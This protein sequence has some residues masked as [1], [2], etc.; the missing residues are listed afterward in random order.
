M[1]PGNGGSYSDPKSGLHS[2]SRTFST[3]PHPRINSFSSS[4]R[5]INDMPWM[6][7]SED[8]DMLTQ[9]GGLDVNFLTEDHHH[10]P[11][12]PSHL[13]APQ[14]DSFDGSHTA[15]PHNGMNYLAD[16]AFEALN[17][18]SNMVRAASQAH[19]ELLET[20]GPD[21]LANGLLGAR[22]Q[23]LEWLQRYSS[24][25]PT[26]GTDPLSSQYSPRPPTYKLSN[27]H[28]GANSTATPSSA[29]PNRGV[30][31]TQISPSVAAHAGRVEREWSQSTADDFRDNSSSS[32][33][34]SSGLDAAMAES[35]HSP[36]DR[37]SGTSG[38]VPSHRLSLPHGSP[39]VSRYA[40]EDSISDPAGSFDATA[41]MPPTKRSRYLPSSGN[42]GYRSTHS[43]R[44][45][46]S[47]NESSSDHAISESNRA[48]Q[49]ASEARR[50]SPAATSASSSPR[51]LTTPLAHIQPFS[52]SSR[53][54]SNSSIIPPGSNDPYL[55]RQLHAPSALQGGLAVAP[56]FS[57]SNS[58]FSA[59][60]NHHIPAWVQD[61]PEIHTLG[62]TSAL[63]SNLYPPMPGF[64]A[65][66]SA[67][68]HPAGLVVPANLP[69]QI[70]ASVTPA[71]QFGAIPQPY[72]ATMA[73]IEPSLTIDQ[74]IS[75]SRQHA[76][77]T[78]I[79]TPTSS[80]RSGKTPN[81]STANYDAP[82]ITKTVSKTGR[83]L[84]PVSMFRVNPSKS[85]PLPQVDPNAPRPKG[86]QSKTPASLASMIAPG[87]MDSFDWKG[88]PASSNSRKRNHAATQ[89][90][91]ESSHAP[92]VSS[93]PPPSPEN[94]Q[95]A[96]FQVL[97]VLGT[98]TFGKVHLCRHKATG[99]YYCLK[100]LKK[101]T[102]FRFKQMDHVENEK[103]LLLQLRYP[104][105]VQLY[106]TYTTEDSLVMLMEYVPGGELFYYIRRSGRLDE[107]IA[108]FYAAELVCTIMHLH[109]RNIVYRDLKP[110][111]ILLDSAGH[112]KL[113]DF[114]FAK[115]VLHKTWTMCG[116]P[117]YLA[118]EI[119]SG[120]G[121]DTAVDW[122]SLGVLI[123][124]ML[125]GYPPFT[126][127]DMGTLFRKIQEPEKLVIPVEFSQEASDL[128]RRLLVADP[129]SRL[130]NIHPDVADIRT[131]PWFRPIHWDQVVQRTIPGPIIPVVQNPGD[132]AAHQEDPTYE[133]P[134]PV[135][136]IP[137]DVQRI[138]DRF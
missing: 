113:A 97:N 23:L 25:S 55:P 126:D 96:D 51:A 101:Q 102:I 75:R 13:Y 72:S 133:T 106:S 132:M 38:G 46:G 71:V 5:D 50:A 12:I 17:H 129:T 137:E 84:P 95:L 81:A 24:Q 77:P 37:P 120:K 10:H 70:L 49:Q 100:V 128:V 86:N 14:I 1:L 53:P 98:G 33:G 11:H 63:P 56:P 127:K 9:S 22:Q 85:T 64:A 79:V 134:A 54:T 29:G 21:Q 26:P 27:S 6:D 35:P 48:L 111:N 103:Q 20:G 108:R 82:I 18:L 16:E 4:S 89:N 94:S 92:S 117:D 8:S 62:T 136:P 61:K 40:G 131:H 78:D 58:H 122:W 69:P 125:A 116:T 93:R 130:G 118:P 65:P 73:S 83:P 60:P 115:R 52:N 105:I 114:G 39:S 45:S 57:A 31:H 41:L 43:I 34:T 91:N 99:L 138:F 15:A 32:W 67:F 3:S 68:G 112:L 87:L 36:E 59:A 107:N 121:H 2:S 28:Y 74:H 30:F 109:E 110:E 19:P 66:A 135:M 76:P 124:E 42:A 47:N 119:I 104:G 88:R 80:K 7:A 90:H 44:N 123:F